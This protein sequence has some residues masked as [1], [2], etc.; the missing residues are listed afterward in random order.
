ME[1]DIA[2]VR[3]PKSVQFT[4]RI[5]PVCLA[6]KPP[7][8]GKHCFIAGWGTVSAGGMVASHLLE[9]SV[10]VIMDSKCSQADSYGSWYKVNL[11]ILYFLIKVSYIWKRKISI[12]STSIKISII[13]QKIKCVGCA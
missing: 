2:L 13:V 5:K 11:Q 4:N 7:I 8:I 1:N 9:A 3:L 6:T 10:P 12:I